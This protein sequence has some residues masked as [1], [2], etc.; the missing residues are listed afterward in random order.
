MKTNNMKT[1]EIDGFC[2]KVKMRE[3]IYIYENSD[4]SK[5]Y[6]PNG[7]CEVRLTFNEIEDD[8]YIEELDYSYSFLNRDSIYSES[9]LIRAVERRLIHKFVLENGQ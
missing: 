1:R 2:S 3:S 6:V 5:W 9:C 8:C 4:G 7:G